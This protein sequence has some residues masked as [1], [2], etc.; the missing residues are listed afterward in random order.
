[1][2][3]TFQYQKPAASAMEY[4]LHIPETQMLASK[5][6]QQA[7]QSQVVPRVQQ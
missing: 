4:I 2:P 3:M 7:Q 1:M 6:I 5:V